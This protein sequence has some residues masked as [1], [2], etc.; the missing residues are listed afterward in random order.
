MAAGVGGWWWGWGGCC[1]GCGHQWFGPSLYQRLYWPLWQTGCR[2]PSV[3]A[4]SLSVQC[5]PCSGM[6]A[7]RGAIHWQPLVGLV[8]W[9]GRQDHGPGTQHDSDPALLSDSHPRHCTIPHLTSTIRAQVCPA[10]GRVGLRGC[11]LAGVQR[12]T[13]GGVGGGTRRSAARGQPRWNQWMGLGPGLS[14][15]RFRVRPAVSAKLQTPVGVAVSRKACH[16]QGFQSIR[17]TE[18]HGKSRTSTEME[19]LANHGKS[20]KITE[21]DGNSLGKSRKQLG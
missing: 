19:I 17:A 16:A 18:N 6:I 3:P 4:F 21:T 5:L 2:P 7:G 9:T 20:R 10:R 14:Q 8:L 13:A 12:T 15:V 11:S 1:Q